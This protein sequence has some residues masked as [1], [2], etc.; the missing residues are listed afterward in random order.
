MLCFGQEELLDEYYSSS[1]VPKELNENSADRVSS[2]FA[3]YSKLNNSISDKDYE[4]FVYRS[5]YFLEKLNKSGEVFY[6]DTISAYLNKLLSFLVSGTEYQGKVKVYLTRNPSF[7]AFTNDFGNIY[8]N[9][10][11]LSKLENETQLLALLAHEV[12][13]IMESHTHEF[14]EFNRNISKDR[15]KEKTE[16]EVLETHAFSK[17]QEFE[18]DLAGFKLLKSKNVDLKEAIKIFELLRYDLNPNIQGE[19]D[20]SLLS[21]GNQYVHDYLLKSYDSLKHHY[22]FIKEMDN[23]SFR[24]HPLTQKRYE[25]ILDF[26]GDDTTSR[27]EPIGDFSFY[28]KLSNYLLLNS[29]LENEWIIEGLGHVLLMRKKYPND[30]YLIKSQAKFLVSLTQHKYNGSAF[31]Q[32]INDK[33]SS[34]T[35][36]SYLLFREL[37][38]SLNALE[39]N[40]LSILI[41]SELKIKSNDPYLD[42]IHGYLIRFIYKYNPILFTFNGEELDFIKASDT[43][44]IQSIRVNDFDTFLTLTIDQ[45]DFYNELKKERGLVSVPI[46]NGNEFRTLMSH[47]LMNYSMTSQDKLHIEKF[48]SKRDKYERMLTIDKVL[49]SMDPKR[50]LK[51]YKKGRYE[52]TK[53]FESF[54]STILVQS[55]NYF[56]KRQKRNYTVDYKNSLELERSIESVFRRNSLVSENYS[57]I[58]TTK[59]DIRGINYHY[60]LNLWIMERFQY[61]DL[62]Y[63]S[64]DEQIEKL[65]ATNRIK[66]LLYNIN[67]TSSGKKNITFGYNL[68]F[69]LENEGIAY[70]SKIASKEKGTDTI[71]EQLFYLSKYYMDK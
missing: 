33:G 25:K 38:L 61:N 67:V 51:Y 20:F 19:I 24:T 55:T 8:V 70:V 63:S 35:D 14:E 13:H 22:L 71:L 30:K 32:F 16:V 6:G 7:N 57:N 4:D 5:N 26:I 43:G 12:S 3:F 65:K 17:K 42:R 58:A 44:I 39:T 64:V 60:Y 9:I 59:L 48:K 50:A 69:D 10:A 52:K 29:F 54:D 1:Y 34:Y 18:A 56:I 2:L 53:F 37:I 28:S 41:N 62:I 27:I 31:G 49:I 47:F 66:Y 46:R 11:A 68:F 15:W 23:D 21:S 45:R 40:L 36:S